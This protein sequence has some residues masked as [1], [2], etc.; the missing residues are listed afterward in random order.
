[1]A[2]LL[3]WVMG[4]VG[5]MPEFLSATSCPT[6]SLDQ[7]RSDL[8]HETASRV[9]FLSAMAA[10]WRRGR[11]DAGDPDRCARVLADLETNHRRYVLLA[12]ADGRTWRDL[13]AA[14]ASIRALQRRCRRLRAAAG[15]DASDAAIY[16]AELSRLAGASARLVGKMTALRAIGLREIAERAIGEVRADP[17]G[18]AWPAVA[19]A[20]D[21]EDDLPRI[22]LP[23]DQS[24]R[25]RD[26]LRNILRNAVQA[27]RQRWPDATGTCPAVRISLRRSAVGSGV[28]IRIADQG[29]GM[30]REQRERSWV[31][32]QTANG[33]GR[34]QGLT[35]AKRAF[36]E[37]RACLSVESE[38]GQGTTVSL[39]FPP[40]DVV[41]PGLLPWRRPVWQFMATLAALAL[42]VNLQALRQAGEARSVAIVGASSVRGLGSRGEVIWDRELA[43]RIL[44]NDHRFL[45]GI[46]DPAV[47]R[48]APGGKIEEIVAAT[49]ADDGSAGRLSFLDGRGNVKASREVAWVA[50]RDECSADL[51]SFWQAPVAW[52]GGPKRGYVIDVRKANKAPESIQVVTADGRDFG[53]YHH[54]GQIKFFA[55]GDFDD[56]GREEF[57]FFGI[58]NDAWRDS[59]LVDCPQGAW[60]ACAALLDPPPWRGQA[61][62]LR[63]WDRELPARERA[64]LL[65]PPLGCG[66]PTQGA[67]TIVER[68]EAAG[69]ARLLLRLADGRILQTDGRL[70][71]I[72][73]EVGDVTDA[74][75]LAMAGTLPDPRVA[76]FHDGGVDLI[77]VPRQGVVR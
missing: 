28:E 45:H 48:H 3:D 58:N 41:A 12:S 1:M 17:G 71:P 15:L 75:R 54:P 16:A 18:P 20:L 77:D 32:G 6:R 37:A 59:L 42:F 33:P 35:E 65:I 56:D 29:I 46:T 64:Y 9:A 61:Y 34:G 40:A 31:A 52:R 38:P 68:I 74:A 21:A 73:Y 76:Y 67:V 49:L 69:P 5:T 66:E 26:V 8:S 36:V 60:H 55:C 14:L 72:C 62:P 24:A 39:D 43:G 7:L 30:S 50:P 70:R 51:G 22:W 44:Q 27:T 53:A 2:G 11:Y 19:I 63:A 57:L 47:Y 10:D 13:I 23:R 25:W 4:V